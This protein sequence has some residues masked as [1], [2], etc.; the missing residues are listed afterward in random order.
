MAVK[1]L[2][3]RLLFTSV[4]FL[5]GIQSFAGAPL[6]ANNNEAVNSSAISQLYS[7]QHYVEGI[8]PLGER[9]LARVPERLRGDPVIQQQVYRLLLAASARTINDA[10]VG[11]RQYPMFV[12]ELN[13]GYNIYQPNADTVYKTT[14]IE[15]GGSY[16]LTGKRGTILFAKLSQLGPDML[17][18]GQGA[19]P[20]A[21]Y[22]FDQLTLDAEGRYRLL[23]S[24]ER[25]AGYQGDWWQLNA[26]AEKLML[27]QISYDWPNEEDTS[28]AIER[29]DTPAARPAQTA[30]QMSDRLAELASMIDNGAS[31]FVDHVEALRNEGYLNKLKVFDVSN[32]SGLENQ[33]YYEGAYDINDNEAL[34]V[35]VEIPKQCRYWSLILTNEVYQTTDWYNNHS[36]INGSQGVIDSDGYFRAVISAKD[37]GVVNWLDT[38]GFNAG[39]IQGRWLE[40]SGTPLPKVTVVN[41]SELTAHLPEN[42]ATIS[43][44][45]REAVIRARRA[46][47]QLRRLW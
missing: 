32:M 45:E 9:V 37:P 16:R 6:M 47:L 38:A 42:T 11:D 2:I 30:R 39:A 36:S 34:I 25:P 10:L 41:F 1:T 20:I 12:P 17:R 3:N 46:A 18:T 29:L 24:P 7:W 21:Y 22:D 5:N 35:E 33:S 19:P 15:A 44:A 27:R 31:F 26:H 4:I 14:M 23:I 28:I 8:R 43:L 40:C 13:I